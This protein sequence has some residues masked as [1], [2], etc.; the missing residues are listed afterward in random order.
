MF[1]EILLYSRKISFRKWDVGKLTFRYYKQK[2]EVHLTPIVQKNPFFTKK[3]DITPSIQ[4][5]YRLHPVNAIHYNKDYNASF[6]NPI[7]ISL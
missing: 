7:G 4:T 3:T 1:F 6:A 2:N 5:S